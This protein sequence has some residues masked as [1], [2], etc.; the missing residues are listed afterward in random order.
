MASGQDQKFYPKARL[1][2]GAGDLV[3]VTEVTVKFSKGR[4][5]VGTLRNPEAGVTNGE[6]ANEISFKCVLSEDGFERDYQSDFD[7]DTFAQYRLKVPGTTYSLT[8]LIDDLEVTSTKDGAIE[9][10]CKV[11]GGQKSS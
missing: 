7:N 3:D 4:K 9:F 10:S 6:H 5:Q 1:S 8:G 11:I 2:K